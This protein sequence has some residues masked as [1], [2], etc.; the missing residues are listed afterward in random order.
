MSWEATIRQAQ[1]AAPEPQVPD[2]LC[3]PRQLLAR[4]VVS[5]DAIHR[6]CH[7]DGYGD[8]GGVHNLRDSLC[9]AFHAS[10]EA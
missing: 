9:V 2:R 10:E 4:W 6:K 8:H 3:T 1:Q 5:A 7:A